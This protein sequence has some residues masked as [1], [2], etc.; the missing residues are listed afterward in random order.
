MADRIC[1]CGH[2]VQAHADKVDDVRGFE[3][4]GWGRCLCK[5]CQCLKFIW[6]GSAVPR[7]AEE[8]KE[9][10]EDDSGESYNGR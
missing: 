6:R 3:Y 1:T 9:V 8:E 4:R 10:S 5:G 7:E 2:S